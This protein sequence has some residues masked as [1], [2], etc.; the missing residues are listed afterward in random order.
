MAALDAYPFHDFSDWTSRKESCDRSQR[1]HCIDAAYTNKRVHEH[2]DHSKLYRQNWSKKY[3]LQC[4]YV[5]IGFGVSVEL[6]IIKSKS[7]HRTRLGLETIGTHWVPSAYKI[8]WLRTGQKGLAIH[9][10][11]TIKR[12]QFDLS[13]LHMPHLHGG[14]VGN[15]EWILHP[16]SFGKFQRVDPWMASPCRGNMFRSNVVA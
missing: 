15:E 4:R 8:L 10:C 14:L 3:T 12:H 1:S 9:A 7:V 13:L 11:F 2:L 5:M 6:Q 16:L